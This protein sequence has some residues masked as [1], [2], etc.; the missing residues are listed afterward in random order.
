M[1]ITTAE[2]VSAFRSSA[3]L[4][5][6]IFREVFGV[7]SME[8]S[9][10]A[11][12]PLSLYDD[13][14]RPS[15]LHIPLDAI[16]GLLTFF[17]GEW[18]AVKQHLIGQ[19]LNGYREPLVLVD[20]GANVGFFSRQCANKFPQIN[21]F[22]CYEPNPRNFNLLVRNLAALKGVE[23][24]N[25]GISSVAGEMEFFLDPDNH[26][27]FSLNENAM[28]A[29]YSKTYVDMVDGR[30]IQEELLRDND[31]DFIY[32]SDTQGHDQVIATTFDLEFW[33][34]VR[35]A[36]LELWRI[37]GLAYD[38]SKFIS[39]VSSF[40]NRRF[41]KNLEVNVTASEILQYLDSADGE[42]DD[43]LLWR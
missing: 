35:V 30:A 31:S 26:G 15:N 41:E 28:P 1:T 29:G 22:Y 42:F 21:K 40:P 36:I 7:I 5:F 43:L 18:D 8:I 17:N 14:G 23:C 20:I 24:R 2:V 6:K 25:C 12:S 13:E 4:N 16:I 33:K 34:R 37:P 11:N 19:M 39:I 38:K 3:H 10:A 9:P 27:N 32:K